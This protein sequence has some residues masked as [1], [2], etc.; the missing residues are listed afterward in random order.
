MHVQAKTMRVQFF[1]QWCAKFWWGFSLYIEI[2]DYF[3]V[4]CLFCESANLTV[5]SCTDVEQ[6]L[7]K[8]F[9]RNHMNKWHLM[10]QT[11]PPKNS[12]FGGPSVYYFFFSEIW[13]VFTYTTIILF[14]FRWNK[15]IAERITLCR[16]SCI[17]GKWGGRNGCPYRPQ[18]FVKCNASRK[19]TL[20]GTEENDV[21]SELWKKNVNCKKRRRLIHQNPLQRCQVAHLMLHMNKDDYPFR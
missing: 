15:T 7:M 3:F 12:I 6:A 21:T 17:F 1:L 13:S 9:R 20:R 19:R 11:T 4:L 8:K 10:V 5:L 14:S 2:L 16:G 18:L